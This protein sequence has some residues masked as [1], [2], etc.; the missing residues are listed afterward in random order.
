MPRRA[1]CRLRQICLSS[2][3]RRYAF[4]P[5]F[6][7]GHGFQLRVV[8][9]SDPLLNDRYAFRPSFDCGH[10][11]QLR[12][13]ASSDP[14]LNDR[15][16]CNPSSYRRERAG[17]AGD[18]GP[19]SECLKSFAFDGGGLRILFKQPPFGLSTVFPVILATAM[20][21]PKSKL[22]WSERLKG[23]A[24]VLTF[25][26]HVFSR[27]TVGLRNASGSLTIFTAILRASSLLSNLAAERRPGSSSK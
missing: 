15:P 3:V 22:M 20:F 18:N 12:V 27:W 14:L 11:F 4:R 17:D 16:R 2:I 23:F 10:G 7:C 24:P 21:K 19:T 1:S 13:V 26:G 6:D 9:S 8:A 5:S 25:V